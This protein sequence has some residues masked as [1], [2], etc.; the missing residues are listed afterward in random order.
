VKPYHAKV[1]KNTKG[2]SWE[3]SVHG[4]DAD[5]VLYDVNTMEEALRHRYGGEKAIDGG[6]AEE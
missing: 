6:G 4:D 3:V 5:Q 1:T 2:Y